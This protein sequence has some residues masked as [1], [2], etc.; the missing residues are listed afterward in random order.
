MSKWEGRVGYLRQGLD[1]DNA[2]L[3]CMGTCAKRATE[4]LEGGY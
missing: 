3:A 1:G 4:I 2:R